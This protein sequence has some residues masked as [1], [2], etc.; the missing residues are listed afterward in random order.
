MK[1]ILDLNE[2]L[3]QHKLAEEHNEALQILREYKAHLA[4]V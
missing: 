3:E 1:P 2:N 4:Q